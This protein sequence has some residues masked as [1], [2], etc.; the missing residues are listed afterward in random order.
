MEHD[1]VTC[2]CRDTETNKVVFT[3]VD[4]CNPGRYVPLN[5]ERE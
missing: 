2:S 1:F 4:R 3:T 5:L